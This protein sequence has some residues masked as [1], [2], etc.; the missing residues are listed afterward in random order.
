MKVI[1]GGLPEKRG[2]TGPKKNLK[3]AGAAVAAAMVLAITVTA[4]ALPVSA[5]EP[6]TTAPVLS[7]SPADA[8]LDDVPVQGDPET[9]PD[10]PEP[11]VLANAGTGVLV[12][13]SSRQGM[14]ILDM[15]DE[16]D[17][18]QGVPA[19]TEPETPEEA[20]QEP[21]DVPETAEEPAAEPVKQEPAAEPAAEPE[22]E[23]DPEPVPEEEPEPEEPAPEDGLPDWLSG[24]EP[25]PEPAPEWLLA[26]LDKAMWNNPY[27]GGPLCQKSWA[28]IP[29]AVTD[30]TRAYVQLD[31]TVAWLTQGDLLGFVG[32]SIRYCGADWFTI[33]GVDDWGIQFPGCN[34]DFA[35]YGP[36]NEYGEVTEA[37]RFIYLGEDGYYAVA[38]I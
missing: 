38:P 6:G 35:V 17:P 24:G 31:T 23:P 25:E 30:G 13:A 15:P 10:A 8:V 14:I 36:L 27:D 20:V 22:P 18:E 29:C 28:E 2:P 37:V 19:D 26:T 1:S 11:D 12:S 7:V 16:A 33:V 4:I 32:N 5:N 3:W 9:G 34:T 21:E